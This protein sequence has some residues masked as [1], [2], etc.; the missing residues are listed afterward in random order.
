MGLTVFVYIFLQNPSFTSLHWAWYNATL[1]TLE[2]REYYP[3]DWFR[4]DSRFAPSP[5]ETVLLCN[6]VSHWLGASLESALLAVSCVSVVS[7]N[8]ALGA[9]WLLSSRNQHFSLWNISTEIIYTSNGFST[10][11]V[12]HIHIILRD[13]IC[14]PCRKFNSALPK[15][16]LKWGHMCNYISPKTMTCNLSVA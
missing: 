9:S 1:S 7:D 16:P 3:D 8:C 10:L 12:D 4:S 13:V 2:I 11:I 15:P 6:A 5:R 14:H